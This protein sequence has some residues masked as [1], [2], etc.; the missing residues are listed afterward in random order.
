MTRKIIPAFILLIFAMAWPLAVSGEENASD[1][2]AFVIEKIRADK[3]LLVAENMF[4][5]HI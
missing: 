3:Q 1:T 2:M 4:D 5:N